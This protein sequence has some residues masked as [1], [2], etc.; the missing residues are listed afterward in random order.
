MDE[1][2]NVRR[3]NVRQ[4]V[5]Q[6]GGAAR[7]TER[8]GYANKGTVSR[9]VDDNPPNNLSHRQARF[10]EERLALSPGTLDR[11]EGDPPATADCDF[12]LVLADLVNALGEQRLAAV[13]EEKFGEICSFVLSRYRANQPIDRRFLMRIIGLAT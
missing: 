8:L 6:H 11:I 9:L 12:S 2:I 4:L 5:K 7:L 10:F 3:K 1:L 13:P